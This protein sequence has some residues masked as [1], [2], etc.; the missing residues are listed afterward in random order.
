MKAGVVFGM[1]GLAGGLLG[2]YLSSLIPSGDLEKILGLFLIAIGVLM[3]Y[4]G[5]GRMGKTAHAEPTKAAPELGKRGSLVGI[6]FGVASGLMTGL[7]GSSG[8]PPTMAGLYFL[9]FPVTTVVG[10]SVFVTMF[11]ALAGLFG[12]V[13]FGQ[14]DL[15][16]TL[17]LCAGASTGAFVGPRFLSRIKGATLDKIY[18]PAFV[19]VMV[20]MG[21]ALLL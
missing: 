18:G 14:F 6:T 10:T 1:G 17:L 3:A 8:T 19:V 20:A 21:I 13:W 11:S 2:A 16:L 5:K 9:G 7:V 12:H 15:T 4:S